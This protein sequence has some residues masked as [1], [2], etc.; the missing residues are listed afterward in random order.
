[1]GVV[2]AVVDSVVVA[3]VV[4]AAVVA[5]V[6]DFVVAAVVADVVGSVAGVCATPGSIAARSFS[7]SASSSTSEGASVVVICAA[8]RKDAAIVVLGCV[9]AG[10]GDGVGT[11]AGAGVDDNALGCDFSFAVGGVEG[12]SVRSACAGKS[13]G[14]D[15]GFVDSGIIRIF[16]VIRKFGV[17]GFSGTGA[18]VDELCASAR[19]VATGIVAKA[20]GTGERSGS[21]SGRKFGR[22]VLSDS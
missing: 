9:G 18:D 8:G 22:E 13:P 10:V 2:A 3:A 19:A 4:V 16:G 7:T 5:A 15:G 11:S 12:V 17:N 1:V 21:E 20:S 14:I 6:V